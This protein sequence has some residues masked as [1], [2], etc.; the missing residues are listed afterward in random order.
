M[1]PVME[2]F[3]TIGYVHFSDEINF[4]ATF[5]YAIRNIM[6]K[7][8]DILKQIVLTEIHIQAVIKNIWTN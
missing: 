7:C 3:V 4:S 1:R 2:Q 5:V 8:K 6:L